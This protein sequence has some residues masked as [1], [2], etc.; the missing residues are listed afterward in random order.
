MD[1]KN[2]CQNWLVN[3]GKWSQ[4]S[5]VFR[6][7]FV[8]YLQG[9]GLWITLW[10][11]W[12]Y[13]PDCNCMNKAYWISIWIRC[14]TY[15]IK[16]LAMWDNRGPVIA[17]YIYRTS[18]GNTKRRSTHWG[19]DKIAAISQTERLNALPWMEMFEFRLNFQWNL[20]SR[21]KQN[22]RHFADDTFKRIFLNENLWIP[23]RIWQIWQIWQ[24]S[25]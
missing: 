10:S 6:Y 2:K 5:V 19:R 13:T 25:N 12:W 11:P 15:E 17:I 22:G 8:W 14:T 4:I 23:I 16:W 7:C 18:C 1:L 9:V 3:C 24:G 20:F 21:S